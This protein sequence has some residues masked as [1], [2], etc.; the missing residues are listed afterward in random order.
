MLLQSFFM[1]ELDAI[2]RARGQIVS[3]RGSSEQEQRLNQS[4]T[5]MDGFSYREGIIVIE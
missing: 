2:G 1:D 4:L 3:I 5:D